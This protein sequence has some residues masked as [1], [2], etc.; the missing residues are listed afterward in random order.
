MTGVV[1]GSVTNSNSDVDLDITVNI[2]WTFNAAIDPN[3]VDTTHFIV[4]KVSDGSVV[5]GSLTIDV[6]NKI[7]TFIPNGVEAS[8]TYNAAAT[9][10]DL[11]SGSGATAP[12]SVNFTT[13]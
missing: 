9:A 2:K 13:I 3:Q 10:I 6:T 12:I 1:G 5:T 7:V 11:L 4:T 8:T